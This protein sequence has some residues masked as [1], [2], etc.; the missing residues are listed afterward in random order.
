ML[1]SGATTAST[2]VPKYLTG[3]LFINGTGGL[4]AYNVYSGGG[5]VSN[6][7]GS[8]VINADCTVSL[9][10]SLG[11]GANQVFNLAVK[12]NN[13]AVGIETDA[14]AVATI[15][16]QPQYSTLITSLNFTNASL[17]GTFAASCIGPKSLSSD[18]N[19]VTFS[20]GSLVGTDPYNNDGAYA[21][22]NNPY[23]GTYTINNDG[24]FTGSLT[25]DGT[26]FDYYGVISNAGAKVEYIYS[27]VS[28]GSAGPA[29][30]SCVGKLAAPVAF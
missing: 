14:G 27:A 12:Q 6:A 25:V 18:L 15:D 7:Q 9:T 3:A 22:A 2:P 8:Y 1:V 29:F 28:N 19:L 21:V 4:A 17:N 24:T 11:G 20:N 10:L 26:P 13:E 23:T 30:A 16:L 5:A